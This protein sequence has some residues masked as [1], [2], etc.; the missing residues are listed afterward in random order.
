MVEDDTEE[1][2]GG[3]HRVDWPERAILDASANV[4]GQQ[5]VKDTILLLKKHVGQLVTFQ[6]AEKKQPKQRRIRALPDSIAGEKLEEPLIISILD[7]LLGGFAQPG[8]LSL[9]CENGR[10][11]CMLGRKVFKKQCFTDTRGL[12]DLFS[13]R[14]GKAVRSKQRCRSVDQTGLPLMAGGS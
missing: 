2:S 11:Q 14:S 3:K 1:G 4:A 5:I 10:V 8:V 6:G 9:F 13:S 12:S 7:G